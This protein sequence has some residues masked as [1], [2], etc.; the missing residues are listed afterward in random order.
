MTL[1]TSETLYSKD[2]AEDTHY[3]FKL[4]SSVVAMGLMD[5]ALL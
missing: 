5:T 4:F 1:A 2:E 3:R